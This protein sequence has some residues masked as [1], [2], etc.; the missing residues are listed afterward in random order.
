MSTALIT[1]GTTGIGHAAVRLVHSQG[2]LVLVT[3]R[4]LASDGG[5]SAADAFA[6]AARPSTLVPPFP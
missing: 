4:N 6:G 2:Y 3:G 1:G 5:I